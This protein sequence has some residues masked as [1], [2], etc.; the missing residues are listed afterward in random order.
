MKFGWRR[1]TLS[2]CVAVCTAGCAGSLHMLWLFFFLQATVSV[3]MV[4]ETHAHTYTHT[5][6]LTHTFA[7][8]HTH[9]PALSLTHTHMPALSHT[10]TH[11]L[12]AG[13]APQWPALCWFGFCPQTGLASVP[14]LWILNG[15][16]KS[17]LSPQDCVHGDRLSGK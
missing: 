1:R 5:H 9:M 13:S 4:T 10:H 7:H 14:R 16:S 6:T 12:W 2:Q 8:T 3:R 15:V 17:R 11:F